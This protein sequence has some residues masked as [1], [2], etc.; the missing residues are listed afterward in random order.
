MI[1]PARKCLTQKLLANYCYFCTTAFLK[2]LTFLK[3]VDKKKKKKMLQSCS[4]HCKV[5]VLRPSYK[6]L[7][8]GVCNGNADITVTISEH[9][10]NEGFDNGSDNELLTLSCYRNGGMTNLFN[11][12]N[13]KLAHTFIQ[14]LKF[15]YIVLAF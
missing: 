9:S 12:C 8:T 13:H 5:S 14:L 4:F 15:T 2:G 1:L 10:C 3:A 11:L 7:K 6:P